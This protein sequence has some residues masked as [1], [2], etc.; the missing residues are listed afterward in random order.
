MWKNSLFLNKYRSK[1]LEKIRKNEIHDP[2]EKLLN[3][4][5]KLRQCAS[6][7]LAEINFNHHKVSPKPWWN[8]ELSKA[9]ENLQ[10]IFNSWRGS[11]FLRDQDNIYYNKY[12]LARKIFRNLVKRE[13][14]QATAEH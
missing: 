2:N 9:R 11:G 13:K 6:D 3:L 7:S 5:C 1:I 12:L 4:F 10:K 8:K 14:N